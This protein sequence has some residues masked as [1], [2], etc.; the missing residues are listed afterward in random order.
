MR[1]SY[2]S[3]TPLDPSLALTEAQSISDRVTKSTDLQLENMKLRDM[4]KETQTELESCKS[5]EF[6][7]KKAQS[8]IAEMEETAK[9]DLQDSVAAN[10][11]RLQE[12]FD[13]RQTEMSTLLTEANDRLSTSEARTRTLAEA[14]QSAQ[15]QLFEF[16][17]RYEELQTAKSKE[18]ELLLGDLEKA[19]EVISLLLHVQIFFKI[20]QHCFV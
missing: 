14:L 17:T 12:D 8:R 5:S 7:L 2:K 18:V 20:F 3:L 1:F 19:N 9:R 13:K 10:L 15:S 6:Q 4:L 16:Q 11:E